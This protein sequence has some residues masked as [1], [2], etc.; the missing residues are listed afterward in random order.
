MENEILKLVPETCPWAENLKTK[1]EE[2]LL[3]L[4]NDHIFSY[5]RQM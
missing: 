1:E 5:L 4:T 2:E 3:L